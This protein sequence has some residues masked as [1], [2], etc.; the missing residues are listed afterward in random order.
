MTFRYYPETDSL[1]IKLRDVKS[2]DTHEVGP[3][4][5]ADYDEEGQVI[6]FEILSAGKLVDLA[7]IKLSHMPAVALRE[8]Q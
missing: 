2:V 1:Y 7:E 6:G 8:G 4:V 3:D 5:M